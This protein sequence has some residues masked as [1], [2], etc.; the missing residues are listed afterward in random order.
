MCSAASCK[1]SRQKIAKNEFAKSQQDSP[2]KWTN[3][4]LMSSIHWLFAVIT[5]WIRSVLRWN[6]SLAWNWVYQ[7]VRQKAG[8]HFSCERVFGF[9]TLFTMVKSTMTGT[10]GESSLSSLARHFI[11]SRYQIKPLGVICLRNKLR[12]V[13]GRVWLLI[14]VCLQSLIFEW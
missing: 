10:K 5:S 11:S 6:L 4:W 8:N 12:V 14:F 9:G 2:F 13:K 3:I 1:L 7:P